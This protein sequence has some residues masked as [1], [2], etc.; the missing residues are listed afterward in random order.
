MLSV[1]YE[2]L[3]KIFCLRA[4]LISLR[5]FELENILY[6]ICTGSPTYLGNYWVMLT[7]YCVVSDLV[8][9]NTCNS[10]AVSLTL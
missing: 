1:V 10:F 4:V 8:P 5:I 9:S 3:D 2:T 6:Y 7:T